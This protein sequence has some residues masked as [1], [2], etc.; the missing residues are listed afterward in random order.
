MSLLFTGT[1]PSK[2]HSQVG[3]RTVRGL[4]EYM[5]LAYD[6]LMSVT[7]QSPPNEHEAGVCEAKAR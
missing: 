1:V 4:F 3:R 5:I 7:T 6:I 2:G